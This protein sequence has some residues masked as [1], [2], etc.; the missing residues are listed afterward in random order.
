MRW[1]MSRAAMAFLSRTWATDWFEQAS[2]VEDD[3]L[4]V[5]IA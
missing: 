2:L 4:D 1:N 5:A 3:R